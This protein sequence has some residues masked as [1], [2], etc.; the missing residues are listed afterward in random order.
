MIK[1]LTIAIILTSAVLFSFPVRADIGTQSVFGRGDERNNTVSIQWNKKENEFQ[2]VIK[3]YENTNGKYKKIKT[4]KKSETEMNNIELNIS[5]VASELKY[6]KDYR[7]TI[8]GKQH[9]IEQ[10]SKKINNQLSF[11]VQSFKDKPFGNLL[12]KNIL[13]QSN[14]TS[15][16]LVNTKTRQTVQIHIPSTNEVA[17][18]EG[19]SMSSYKYSQAKREQAGYADCSSFVW[20]AYHLA[21]INI[22]QNVGT[23]VSELKWCETNATEISLSEVKQGDLIFYADPSVKTSYKKH[24]KHVTHVA[25]CKDKE[26]VI[27][28][29]N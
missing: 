16:Y 1:K 15:D 25:L 14:Q 11:V 5:N 10:K 21:G 29:A 17:V 26:T 22:T 4:I 7:I 23:T 18:L 8:T 13:P 28:M 27:E 19:E 12:L 9:L 24:Y 3:I 6:N 20:Y 2:Y